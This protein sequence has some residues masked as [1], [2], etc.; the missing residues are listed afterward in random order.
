MWLSSGVNRCRRAVSNHP[1]RL[2]LTL[3]M[4]VYQCPQPLHSSPRPLQ[5]P[6]LPSGTLGRSI[7]L[8]AHP[9]GILTSPGSM[10]APKFPHFFGWWGIPG[11]DL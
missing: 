10:A 4:V 2:F 8:P 1:G 9:L 7:I 6:A 3:L 11:V 5:H